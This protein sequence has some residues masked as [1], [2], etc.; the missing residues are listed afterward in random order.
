MATDK[1]KLAFGSGSMSDL[2]GAVG[3]AFFD[4]NSFG[5]TLHFDEPDNENNMLRDENGQIKG[6][7]FAKIIAK[8]VDP[9]NFEVKFVMDMLFT[10]RSFATSFE[11]LGALIQ[12][13]ETAPAQDRAVI[14]IRVCNVLNLWLDKVFYDFEKDCPAL[15]DQLQV[16]LDR[17]MKDADAKTSRVTTSVHSILMKRLRGEGRIRGDENTVQ[18]GKAPVPHLPKDPGNTPLIKIH[19]EE[20]ARQLTLLEWSIW[21]EIRAWECLGLAWTKKDKEV[22]APHICE[23]QN[24]FNRISLWVATTILQTEKLQDRAKVLAK[25]IEI[26]SHLNKLNN[27]A[28]TLQIVSGLSNSAVHRLTQTWGTISS[29]LRKTY[30]ELAK[31]NERNSRVLRERIR[32]ANPPCIPFFGMYQTDLTFVE[33]GNPDLI[34]PNGNLQNCTKRRLTADYIRSIHQYQLQPYVLAPLPFVQ[35]MILSAPVLDETTLYDMSEWLEPRK[36]TER[37][38]KPAGF[39]LVAEGSLASEKIELDLVMGYPFYVADAPSNIQMNPNTHTIKYATIT[40]IIEH[41][42]HHSITPDAALEGFLASFR[43]FMQ[44]HELFDLLEK[45]WNMPPPKDKSNKGMERFTEAFQRPIY[46]RVT[47][48]IKSWLERHFYDFEDDPTLKKKLQVFIGQMCVPYSTTLTK[49]LQRMESGAPVV[50]DEGSPSAP[51]LPMPGFDP[52][53]ASILEVDAVELARQLTISQHSQFETIK[54]REC[55]DRASKGANKTTKAPN[56]LRVLNYNESLTLWFEDQLKSADE[57]GASAA[58]LTK[59]LEVLDF[60]S[61]VLRN[62]QL[63]SVVIDAIQAFLPSNDPG[64]KFANLSPHLWTA[65]D[66]YRQ[67]FADHSKCRESLSA[68]PPSILPLRYILT[69]I[70]NIEDRLGKDN[71][72]T[73]INLEKR[74]A[75]GEVVKQMMTEQRIRYNLTPVPAILQMIESRYMTYVASIGAETENAPAARKGA[76]NDSEGVTPELRQSMMDF[77]GTD[78]DFR[79]ELAKCM[80]DIFREDMLL[81]ARNIALGAQDD[82]IIPTSLGSSGGASGSAG[83]GVATPD[84]IGYQSSM[85]TSFSLANGRPMSMSGEIFNTAPPQNS[86]TPKSPSS[87]KF[88]AGPNSHGRVPSSVTI[89]SPRQTFSNGSAAAAAASASSAGGGTSVSP[90]NTPASPSSQRNGD[91]ANNGSS[92]TA[93]NGS[94]TAQLI[95]VPVDANGIMTLRPIPNSDDQ[96]YAEASSLLAKDFGGSIS[97]TSFFDEAGVVYGKPAH[98]SLDVIIKAQHH[99]LCSFSNEIKEYDIHLLVQVGKLYKAH[100][101]SCSL[102]CIVVTRN[103]P[104]T[105][106]AVADRFKMK[107]YSIGEQ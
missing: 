71:V 83:T 91:S 63:V 74:C 8:M 46:M 50:V 34:G 43:S 60:S 102:A 41:M 36:G 3:D 44:P 17:C 10:Y 64:S 39:D 67:I 33:D 21:K 81:Q 51:I 98:I 106:R 6:A 87:A 24:R 105:V 2:S 45:R 95:T 61:A 14:L 62:W 52:V 38:P 11:V 78:A 12:R 20:I 48:L 13:Y 32:N 18:V 37:G 93:N 30:E 19:A 49:V 82:F 47:N 101:P 16:F 5:M 94:T 76:A 100:T 107:V 85:M 54:P 57:A 31:Y 58:V 97:T 59:L 22:R 80:V 89:S 99:Y 65:Y 26:A 70:E 15:S 4:P 92:S 72:G 73:L 53:T 1:P 69:E 40:K 75:A 42:T 104:E 68:V 77:I 90:T 79:S 27:F 29:T 96:L 103:I 9:Q 86:F 35:D 25:F 55:M 28:G 88:P 66:K 84:S 56:V 23:A 7:S